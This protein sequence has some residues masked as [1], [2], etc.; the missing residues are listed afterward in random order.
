M[1]TTFEELPVMLMAN[2]QKVVFIHSLNNFSGSPNVLSI[3]IKG[4]LRKGYTVELITSHGEGFLSDLEG[5]SYRYTCYRWSANKIKTLFWLILSQVQ[6]FFMIL[7]SSKSNT[8]YFINTIVPFGAA[9]ACYLSNKRYIYHVHENMQQD[10]PV[11]RIFRWTYR[12]FNR[13]SIFVSQY[14]KTTALNCRNGIV[15]HNALDP[16]FIKT[17]NKYLSIDGNVKSN[18]LMVASLRKFKGVYEFAELARELPHYPFELVLNATDKEVKA[19]ADEIKKP[20]NLTIYSAQVNM[21]PFYK[22]AKML[23][24][25]SHPESWVE[26]FGLTILEAMVY[27]VPAIVP[28]VGGPTELVD[29]GLNGFLVDPH[30]QE[31]IISKIKLLMQDDNKYATFSSSALKKSTHFEEEKMIAEIENYL[32]TS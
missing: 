15:I 13:K 5:I 23:L 11:Y 14:L 21:H 25:L 18:I 24:Q 31:D 3:V 32:L 6:L 20:E 27:G 30:N 9:L 19:F 22:R 7:L 10:K 28:N 1:D 26:T 29:D 17:A 4:F 16:D 12:K 8:T 2:S